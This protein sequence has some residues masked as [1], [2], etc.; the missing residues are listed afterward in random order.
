MLLPEVS[1]VAGCKE[2]CDE[3]DTPLVS[4]MPR[5]VTTDDIWVIQ[6]KALGQLSHNRLH[7]LI[8]QPVYI[9]HIQKLESSSSAT[10]LFHVKSR[11][12]EYLLPKFT[13]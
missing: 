8:H 12:N 5:F 6:L 7:L 10:K 11:R 2:L 13:F 4:V 3:I 1:Q 9:L